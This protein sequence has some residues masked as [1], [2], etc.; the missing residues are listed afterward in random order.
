[1][2][3]AYS[4]EG[5]NILLDVNSGLVHVADE[6]IVNIIKMINQDIEEGILSSSCP[7]F[8]VKNYTEKVLAVYS[9]RFPGTSVSREEV[10]EAL[11][12][13]R[14]LID[15]D[16]LYTPDVYFPN[17]EAINARKTAIKAMCLHIAHDCNLAC[18]YCFAEG[19]EYHSHDRSLMS[20]ETG[21]K[22]LDFL[23]ENSGN[24]VNLEVD[25]FGGEPLMN[26]D[27]VKQLVAYGRS[28]EKEK[29]K[30]FRFTLTT[31]AMLLDDEITEFLNQEM[32][33]VV[34]SIDGRKEVND[35]MRVTRNGKGSFDII[36][37]N[38]FR[39]VLRV[40]KQK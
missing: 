9:E 40:I 3:H 11:G 10:S 19:G 13:I 24:R 1:M 27:V 8:D 29:N 7:E 21:K 4:L 31:N 34:L 20:F 38:K 22:A 12:E 18:K 26:F 16:A 23:V 28:I 32:A 37:V 35:A 14:E 17:I 39:T 25:F 15:S 2:V 36:A 5:Y 6:L 33:N 30:N